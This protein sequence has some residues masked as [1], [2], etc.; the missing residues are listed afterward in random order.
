[1]G[2]YVDIRQRQL[3][4]VGK[5]VPAKRLDGGVGNLVSCEVHQPLTQRDGWDYRGYRD[6]N[7]GH[8]FKIHPAVGNAVNGVSYQYGGVQR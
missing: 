1:M 8:R 2:I 5:R 7:G 3:L 6:K 4:Q